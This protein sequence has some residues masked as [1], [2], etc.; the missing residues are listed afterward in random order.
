MITFLSSLPTQFFIIRLSELFLEISK[1]KA[2]LLRIAL[3]P[4]MQVLNLLLDLLLI[5][6]FVLDD[7]LFFLPLAEGSELLG[8]GGENVST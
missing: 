6:C 8:F 1:T 2:M 7:S 3:N 5:K 4:P